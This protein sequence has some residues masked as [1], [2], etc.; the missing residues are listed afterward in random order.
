M[1]TLSHLSFY[2][3]ELRKENKIFNPISLNTALFFLLFFV[4]SEKMTIFV[5]LSGERLDGQE[6]IAYDQQI[7]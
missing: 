1:K 3:G 5:Y 7:G 6:I 4:L 2:E